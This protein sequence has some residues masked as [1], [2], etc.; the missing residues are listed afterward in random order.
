MPHLQVKNIPE[1]VYAAL[2]QRAEAEGATIRDYVLGLVTRE[3]ARPSTREW[4]H[5]LARSRPTADLSSAEVL[6]AIDAGRDEIESGGD[7]RT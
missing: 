6:A 2:R 3:L 4:L 7:A 1:P 5:E